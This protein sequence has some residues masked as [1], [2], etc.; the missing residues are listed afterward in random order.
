MVDIGRQDGQSHAAGFG[1]V[2]KGAVESPLV[3]DDGR[4]EFGGVMDLQVGRLKGDPGIGGT[5]GF[6][7]RVAVEAHDHGPDR[8]GFFTG[9]PFCCGTGHK[10]SPEIP[11]LLLPVL[12]GQD[13]SESVR[14]GVGETGQR[15]SRPR[16]IFL[17]D[18]DAERFVQHVGEKRMDGVPRPAVQPADIFLDEIVGCRAD[19]AAVDHQVLEITHPGFLLQ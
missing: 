19:D 10:A 8:I 17:V 18:H 1:N 2:G 4:H 5:V 6:A 15:D 11:E 13:L 14:V 16:Y 9:H 3:T 12:F 7:E